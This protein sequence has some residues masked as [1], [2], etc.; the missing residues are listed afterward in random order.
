MRDDRAPHLTI[1]NRTGRNPPEIS[2]SPPRLCQYKAFVHLT[3][4]M[5]SSLMLTQKSKAKDEQSDNWSCTKCS[6]VNEALHLV[7]NV[8]LSEKPSII[9]LD[10]DDAATATIADEGAYRGIR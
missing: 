4:L 8:C 1:E 3:W 9:E 6:Y 10:D 7:C 2:S 5:L